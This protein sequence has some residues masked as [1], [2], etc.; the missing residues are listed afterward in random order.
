MK[1]KLDPV[2]YEMLHKRLDQTLKEARETIVKLS[3]SGVTREAREV[4]QAFF[5]P[6]GDTVHMASAMLMHIQS[7]SSAIK[8][9]IK[10]GYSQ[11]IGIHE[12][13]QFIHND[14]HLAGM[15]MPDVFM[16]APF[17]YKGK[18]A[19]WTGNFTH[20][21]EIGA[22]EPGGVAPGAMDFYHEGLCFPCV[23]LVEKGIPKR[24]LFNMMSRMVRDPRSIDIDTRAK[25]GGNETACRSL[26]KIIDDFGLDFFTNACHENIREGEV[27]A[28]E[29]LKSL[30]P[31]IYRSRLFSD[32][33]GLEE[34]LLM[35]EI[36]MEITK[37]RRL[38]IHVPV[39]SPQQAGYN[40]CTIHAVQGLTFSVLLEQL[41]YDLRWN[42]G[43]FKVLEYN[44]SCGS[45]LNADR[46]AAVGYC[47][48]GIG[49]QAMGCM[50]EVISRAAFIGK[51]YK[52]IYCPSPNLPSVFYGGIDQFGRRCAG[53][54]VQ[55][56]AGFGARLDRDGVDSGIY[57]GNTCAE[58]PDIEADEM[59][60][61][62]IYLAHRTAVDSG[63]IGKHRGGAVPE[64]VMSVRNTPLFMAGCMGSGR[65]V[66]PTQG[67]F[68]GYPG[69]TTC[70]QYSSNTNLN[71][72]IDSNGEIPYRVDEINMLVKGEH[73][74][75]PIS[76][77]IRPLKEGDL[78]GW[79]SLGAG[80]CGDPLERDPGAVM[81]DIKNKMTGERTA[82]E[83]YGVVFDRETL[84]IDYEKTTK[85]RERKRKD[86]LRNGI[87]AKQYIKDM[88]EKRKRREYPVHILNLIDELSSFSPSFLT[89]L[90]KEEEISGEVS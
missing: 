38:I 81:K 61:P 77:K 80:G 15:H 88:V 83:I 69:S 10:E 72:L 58:A 20:I 3:T 62:F 40:N 42:S 29:R 37:D 74:Y 1:N 54:N 47:P 27:L 59:Q 50:D 45:I 57:H 43:T 14:P 67:L 31:G 16:I 44:I 32:S 28:R 84:K 64:M 85:L 68:G 25:I 18:L 87:P 23:K 36:D 30:H 39:S 55:G 24:D 5:L 8:Y 53:V 66:S 56:M 82:T 75:L 11:D 46:T 78:I 48:I 22:I 34:K 26:A 63:G 71:E 76:T 90:K 86:R 19:G 13:D 6:D 7:I 65:L 51:R 60:T 9:M 49:S 21:A 73:E 2:K 41:F 17:F 89:Q 79:K 12:G 35:I 4:A 70:F 52:D 33:T